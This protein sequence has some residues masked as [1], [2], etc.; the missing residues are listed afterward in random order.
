M[1]S[2]SALYLRSLSQFGS[3]SGLLETARLLFSV[4]A[5]KS[6]ATAG[7][8]AQRS[9]PRWAFFQHLHQASVRRVSRV[10][11]KENHEEFIKL[12]EALAIRWIPNK[13]CLRV[14]LRGQSCII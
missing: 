5:T 11:P 7:L 6:G 2:K 8:K 14:C 3:Q 1:S 10:Q 12:P 9:M 13:G 4:I